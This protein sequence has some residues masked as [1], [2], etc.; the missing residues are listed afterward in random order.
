MLFPKILRSK[1]KQKNSKTFNEI[2]L[3]F[4]LHQSHL[5]KEVIAFTKRF[6]NHKNKHTSLKFLFKVN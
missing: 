2:A 1:S 4:R 6:T 3:I 5:R